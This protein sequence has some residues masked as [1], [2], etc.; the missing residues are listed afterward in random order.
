MSPDIFYSINGSNQLKIKLEENDCSI[1]DGLEFG[2]KINSSVGINLTC[3]SPN[4]T[5][6]QLCTQT[7]SQVTTTATSPLTTTSIVTEPSGIGLIGGIAGGA[8]VLIIL[9]L[10]LI[11]CLVRR[12]RRKKDQY[13]QPSPYSEELL[14]I[15]GTHLCNRFLTVAQ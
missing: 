4:V 7:T 12:K 10:I 3:Y 2:I 9:I 6:K 11:I 8:V 13:D 5:T 1:N 14:W 15:A